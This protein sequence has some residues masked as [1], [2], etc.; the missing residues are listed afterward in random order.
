MSANS[1][2]YTRRLNRCFC[3]VATL[4]LVLAAVDASRPATHADA[5]GQGYV[6]LAA[7]ARILDTR[8][9]GVTVDDQFARGGAR[10]L[11]STLQL[12]VAGRAGVPSGAA[13]V[14]LNVTVT[15]AQGSGVITVFPC[16]AG[17][18]T[19]SNLN[20]VANT[21]V[22][23]MVIAKIGA[24]GLVCVF[25]S[26]STDLVVDVAGYYSGAQ[27]FTAL[28]SPARLLDSRPGTTTIDGAFAGGGLRPNGGT[29]VLKVTGRAG[30]PA[31]AAT[32][33]LNVTVD[34]TQVAG[35]VTVY[36][37]GAIPTASN[38]N[39]T[40]AKTVPNA[41]ISKLSAAGTVCLYNSGATHLIV[42][43]AGYFADQS[44]LVPLAAPARLLDTRAGFA[45]VDG[46][47]SGIGLRPSTG[48][49][50]LTVAGR[51]K[52]P[53]NA[54]AVVLNVT[55]DQPQASGFI[56]DYPTGVTRPNA[57]SLNYVAGQ[58]VPNAVI[59]TLGSG[60]SVCLFSLGATQLIVDVAGYLTGPAPVAKGSCPADVAPP[61]P[62]SSGDPRIVA[63][64]DVACDPTSSGFNNGNGTATQ[65]QQR[66]TSDLLVNNSYAAVL[67]LG[68]SQY[69]AGAYSAFLGSYDGS[70]GRVKS[71]T[72][73]AP[74]NHE[75]GTPGAAGY[76]KYFAGAA[77]DPQKGYYSYDIGTW[78]MVALNSNCG[79]VSCAKG[80]AQETWLRADLAAHPVA[81]TVVYWHHPL[82]SSGEHGDNPGM[83]ALYQ[84]AYDG[85]VDVAL[86]GHD[87]D[88]ERFA[89][90][91]AAGQVDMARGV[92]EFVGGTGGKNHYTIRSPRPNSEV[93]ND[94]TFGVLELTLHPGSYDWK[95]RPIA[96]GTFTD[97][98]TQRCH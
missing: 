54:S 91:N 9:D 25:N 95:F 37:C 17:R 1:E 80:S 60:G 55:V 6:P 39:Y 44:V 46:A 56:T 92:R 84:A 13:S 34:Q 96:G 4:I 48:T 42:D 70:W 66:A 78:H 2:S 89:P 94:N 72:K 65:C 98:G 81:C 31:G 93:R 47:F 30:V 62:S 21:N 7:P 79:V 69:D 20:Y 10:S 23:N 16:E 90:Q 59:A 64:G 18:P 82:Y 57:S 38:L 11:G 88:Y 24:N 36:P 85:G 68:D 49:I 53:A 27:G 28:A 83:A 67:T 74:G 40:A 77:G 86:A 14:V 75:Y 43:V 51:A 63:A 32:V 33:V 5:A 22:A 61:P 73:P 50:Q 52:I 35:F 45:T 87:H 26:A 76:Y 29:V 97:S 3:A 41:V 15:Q 19:A 8:P 58:T 71:I 12:V